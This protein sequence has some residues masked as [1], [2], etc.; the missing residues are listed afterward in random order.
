MPVL[1]G[2][3]IGAW[4]IAGELESGTAGFTFTQ[5][6]GRARWAIG[7]LLML[8]IPIAVTGCLLGLLAS[9]W[10]QPFEQLGWISRWKWAQFNITALTLPAWTVLALCLAVLTGAALGRRRPA[11]SVSLLVIVLAY[12]G[13]QAL[14]RLLLRVLTPLPPGRFWLIQGISA[15]CMLAVAALAAAVTVWLIRG[16]SVPLR[17]QVGD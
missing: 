2:W 7:K 1:T 10:L 3:L 13:H 4:L 12:W 17:R 6:I 5:G 14:H 8:S 16:R 9:W 11:G 15:A